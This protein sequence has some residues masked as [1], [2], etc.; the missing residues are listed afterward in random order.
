[1]NADTFRVLA[2]GFLALAIILAVVA[3][4]LFRVCDIPAVRDALTGRAAEREI[5][6]LR[7]MRAGSWRNAENMGVSRH[8]ASKKSAES[9]A[10]N[11]VTLACGTE[12]VDEDKTSLKSVRN[13]HA[14]ADDGDSSTILARREG[15]N[16]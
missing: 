9:V 2:A 16:R 7:G 15:R 3:A 5:A 11:P 1:M 6:Q 8:K 10:E 4:A 13:N 14:C 12:S